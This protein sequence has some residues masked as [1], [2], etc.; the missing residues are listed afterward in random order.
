[1]IIIYVFLWMLCGAI[2][3]GMMN[4]YWYAK[5]P[6]LYNYKNDFIIEML[7]GLVIGPFQ[8]F[9][10]FIYTSFAK[11]GISIKD[12]SVKYDK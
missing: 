12:L 5:Y 2:G 8:L 3:A 9:C 1:M 7:V 11:D 10:S 4:S 6:D